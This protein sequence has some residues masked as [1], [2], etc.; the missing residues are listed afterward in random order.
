LQNRISEAKL[1]KKTLEIS[2]SQAS[3]ASTAGTGAGAVPEIELKAEEAAH[4]EVKVHV[5]AS[6]KIGEF[7]F[8]PFENLKPVYMPIGCIRFLVPFLMSWWRQQESQLVRS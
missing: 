6:R 5:Q 1:R 3:T 8:N 7:E 2:R 4:M